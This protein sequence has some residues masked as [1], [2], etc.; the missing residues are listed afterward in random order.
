M[1]VGELVV[2]R[3]C[4]STDGEVVLDMGTQPACDHFPP[5]DDPTPDPV[6]PVRLWLCGSCGLAQLAEDPTVPEEPRAVEPQALLD[7]A[8]HAVELVAE[9][10]LLPA[11]GRVL[12]YGSPHGGTWLGMLLARGMV[13]ADGDPADADRTADVVLDTFGLMH[14]ADQAEALC[15]RV[16]RLAPD[17]TLLVQFPSLATVIAHGQWNHVRHGH[18]AYY[19]TPTLQRMLADVGLVATTAWW[20][21]LYGGTVL[22]AARRGGTPSPALKEIVESETAAGVLDPGVLRGLQDASTASAAALRQWLV[23]A[24]ARGRRVLG[25]GAAS[26][27]VPLLNR[28]GVGPELLAAVADASPGKQGRRLPGVGVP[29]VPASALQGDGPIDVLVLVPDLLDEVRRAHP[30]VEE[31][32]GRWVITEPAPRIAPPSGRPTP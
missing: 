26:R 5:A 18:M 16:E 2:C 6:F 11:G 31:H 8:A 12:E 3:F 19:S 17:G 7:Q 21:P 1:T 29:I 4:G 15:A 28:A 27:A 23:D 25:Y 10:G 24:R 22:V 14:D 13:A 20:F 32:G 9:A 30:G